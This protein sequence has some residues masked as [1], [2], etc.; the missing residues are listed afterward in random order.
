M[1]MVSGL[2]ILNSETGVSRSRSSTTAKFE[3]LS[4]VVE[5]AAR[6]C[7]EPRRLTTVLAAQAATVVAR[8]R[9][10]PD[11]IKDKLSSLWHLSLDCLHVIAAR[12][13]QRGQFSPR[14]A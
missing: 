11:Q 4:K 12:L 1:A 10:R 13:L 9:A 6:R 5:S 8:R 7:R 3:P 14:A 2:A